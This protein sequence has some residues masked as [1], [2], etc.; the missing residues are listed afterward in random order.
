MVSPSR[1]PLWID[2]VGTTTVVS[3]CQTTGYG[4]GCYVGSMRSDTE[5]DIRPLRPAEFRTTMYRGR[6]EKLASSEKFLP[7]SMPDITEHEIANVNEA[8]ASTWISS[9][10]HFLDDFERRFADA[11]GVEHALA[12]SSGTTALHLAVASL[13]AGPGDEVIVPTFTYIASAN[14]VSYAGATPV[15]VDVDPQTWCLDP[16]HVS[17]LVTPRTVGIIAVHLYGHPADMDAISQIAARHGL[18]V[19]EDAAEATFGTYKGRTTGSIGDIGVFSFF[20]NKVLSSGEG[21]AVTTNNAHLANKMRLLRGQGMDPERRYYFP[22]IGFN[23][24]LTNVAAALLCA[25]FDRREFLLSARHAIADAYRSTLDQIPGLTPQPI[26][27]WA[28]WTPWLVSVLVDAEQFGIDR[29]GLM[30]AL[31]QARIETRPFFIPMHALPPYAELAKRQGTAF[32]VADRLAASGINLPTFPA[33][34][35]SDVDRVSESIKATH[36]LHRT[37]KS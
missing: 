17:S 12:A 15:F 33:M 23:Y 26:A 13:G 20:G 6:V 27:D 14:A 9:T 1:R 21:G 28:T 7:L 2:A 8:V 37:S 11:C 22:E 4:R 35:S 25:Q 31:A 24:R 3:S 19:I 32:P 29:D 34:G 10:G 18:W 5:Y 16:D 36:L 30:D